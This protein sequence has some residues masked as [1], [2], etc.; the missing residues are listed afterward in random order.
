MFVLGVEVVS[1]WD[2]SLFVASVAP[3]ELLLVGGLVIYEEL[4][5]YQ[6]IVIEHLDRPNA[7]SAL[8]PIALLDVAGII[9]V[10]S[11]DIR[12]RL[13]ERADKECDHK[14]AEDSENNMIR[15]LIEKVFSLLGTT[16][17]RSPGSLSHFRIDFNPGCSLFGGF[18][19]GHFNNIM[20]V[21][22][23]NPN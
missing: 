17:L 9:D 14:Q 5:I 8:Q 10:S 7:E 23:K 3:V 16:G 11:L 2:H 1:F 18:G 13:P 6:L 21:D 22:F 4:C 12:A 19:S 15:V 20:H